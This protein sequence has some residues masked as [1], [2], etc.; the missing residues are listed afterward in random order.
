MK[1]III[2]FFAILFTGNVAY[3]QSS[4]AD[5]DVVQAL[6]GRNKRLII[7]DNMQLEEKEKTFW[8]LYDQYEEKRKGIEKDFFTI[9]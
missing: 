8:D 7:A 2:G 1:T 6:L 3:C 5:I 9:K 4:N